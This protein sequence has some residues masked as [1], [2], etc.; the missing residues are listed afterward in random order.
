MRAGEEEP[1][2]QCSFR[3]HILG[4]PAPLGGRDV[5]E[6]HRSDCAELRGGQWCLARAVSFAHRPLRW[7]VRKR[8][9]C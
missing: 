5:R 4:T 3:G 6:V 2:A 9:L 1:G 8:A 7:I